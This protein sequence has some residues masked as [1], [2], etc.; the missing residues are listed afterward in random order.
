MTWTITIV[1]TGS[2]V[3]TGET[4]KEAVSAAFDNSCAPVSRLLE[5]ATQTDAEILNLLDLNGFSATQG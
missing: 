4:L 5:V 3:G 1:A 2:I